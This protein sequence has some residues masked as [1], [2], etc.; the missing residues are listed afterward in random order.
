MSAGSDRA[1]AFA[2]APALA[3]AL[4]LTTA[5]TAVLAAAPALAQAPPDTSGVATGGSGT[6]ADP[7]VVDIDEALQ[8]GL[9]VFIAAEDTIPFLD[10]TADTVLVTAPRVSVAEVVRRI[11]ERMRADEERMGDHAWTSIVRIVARKNDRERTEYEVVT[12]ERFGRDGTYQNARVREVERKYKD[13]A[14]AEEKV[15]EEIESRWQAVT[16]TAGVIP[17]SLESGDEYNYEI[18]R[19]SLFHD[20]L[21]YEIRYAPKSRFKALPEG[22]VWIDFSDFVIRRLE[23]RMVESVP[24]PMFVRSIPYFKARRVKRGDFWLLDDLMARVELRRVLPGIPASVELY[25]R[26]VDH[27]IDGVRYGEEPGAQPWLTGDL[28]PAAGAPEPPPPGAAALADSSTVPAAAPAAGL[29]PP[30]TLP[31]AADS[32]AAPE[33]PR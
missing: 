10:G 29:A 11:G 24:A 3:L 23:G 15:D 21:I 31:A 8:A 6:E 25:V 32:A 22:T 2:A 7:Y 20:H 18:V 27:E 26:H 14:L 16:E 9:G 17:F 4:A 28:D 30:D 12:R 33:V 5:L 1:A 19:R 13:G